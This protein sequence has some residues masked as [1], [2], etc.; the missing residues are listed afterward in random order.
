MA[1]LDLAAPNTDILPNL[2]IF[3][4]FREPAG[5]AATGG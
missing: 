5:P 4:P 2:T 1:H 3:I